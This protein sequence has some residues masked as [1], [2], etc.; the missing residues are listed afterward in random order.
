[1][2]A[3]QNDEDQFSKPPPSDFE[4]AR[5]PLSGAI[6]VGDELPGLHPGLVET[7]FQAEC[8]RSLKGSFR[9]S[10]MKSWGG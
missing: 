8:F 1:M 4:E 9:Q 3:R 10:S 6:I 7:A 2:I 5:T